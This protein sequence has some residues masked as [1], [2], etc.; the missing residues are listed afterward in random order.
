ML[1]INLLCRTRNICPSRVNLL[2]GRLLCQLRFL[3]LF[4]L[5]PCLFLKS[6]EQEE[7]KLLRLHTL[8]TAMFRSSI[9]RSCNCPCNQPPK[10]G[11]RGQHQTATHAHAGLRHDGLVLYAILFAAYRGGR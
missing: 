10:S 5:N 2:L 8:L 1:R 6:P 7:L 3:L 11:F 9:H 4:L